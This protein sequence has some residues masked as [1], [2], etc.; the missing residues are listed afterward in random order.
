MKQSPFEALADDVHGV[1]AGFQDL[2]RGGPRIEH[3]VGDLERI[4]FAHFGDGIDQFLGHGETP[5]GG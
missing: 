2:E 3:L 5:L 4:L 1:A